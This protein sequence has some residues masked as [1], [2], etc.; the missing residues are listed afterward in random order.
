MI[1]VNAQSCQGNQCKGAV[2]EQYS[3][4]TEIRVCQQ[5]HPSWNQSATN[6]DFKQFEQND[7]WK[8]IAR[9]PITGEFL[10]PSTPPTVK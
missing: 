10:D 9:H 4:I 8:Q 6:E 3:N 1:Q 2:T 7:C 5:L